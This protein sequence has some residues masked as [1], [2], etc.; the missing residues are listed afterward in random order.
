[1]SRTTTLHGQYRREAA[2][3]LLSDLA[4]IVTVALAV[5][6]DRAVACPRP[7]GPSVTPGITGAE[8]IGLDANVNHW[9]NSCEAQISA[10]GQTLYYN[11]D[12]ANLQHRGGVYRS[13]WA[14]PW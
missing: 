4:L 13:R 9:A 7:S 2:L 5:I 8:R 1:M 6:P 11:A 14:E 10:A 3:P 12:H